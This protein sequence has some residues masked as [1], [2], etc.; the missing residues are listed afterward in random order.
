[1]CLST[2]F[3]L[4]YKNP[5]CERLK[6]TYDLLTLEKFHW[7]HYKK[8]WTI[9]RLAVIQVFDFC[10]KE[11]FFFLCSIWFTEMHQSGSIDIRINHTC[12]AVKQ[13]SNYSQKYSLIVQKS[14]FIAALA[15]K[16]QLSYQ[17][18]E[19]NKILISARENCLA[20]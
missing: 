13:G 12:D 15:I 6:M 5:Y 17:F 9:D 10:I 20:S 14:E 3:K 4:E 1:M 7:I 18:K 16:D 11:L 19:W 8:D 2:N